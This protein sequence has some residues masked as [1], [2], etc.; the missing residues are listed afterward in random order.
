MSWNVE[1]TDEFREWWSE[2]NIGEQKDVAHSVRLLEQYGPHLQFPYSSNIKNS[3]YSHMRELRIQHDGDPYRVIY[4][5]DPRRVAMLLTGGCKVGD[6]KDWYKKI[7]PTADSLYDV[8]LAT[9]KREN[10]GNK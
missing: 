10:I 7:I 5:F 9:L 6:D 4:A 3:R 2:L 1:Y 8:H